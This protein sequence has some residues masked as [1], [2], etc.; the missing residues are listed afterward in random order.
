[1]HCP[2]TGTLFAFYNSSNY[3]TM[4]KLLITMAAAI[5]MTS[6]SSC[7]RNF[8]CTCVYPGAAAGTTKTTIKAYNRY[9][10]QE[11][12]TKLNNGARQNGG[13]CAL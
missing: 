2:L 12:C 7:E 5:A 4:K 3:T 10:A 11:T 6:M 8:T 1:M 9:D 13:A